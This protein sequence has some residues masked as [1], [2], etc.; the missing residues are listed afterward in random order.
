MNR[1]KLCLF[2][3]LLALFML[4][5]LDGVQA[6]ETKSSAID[7]F[8]NLFLSIFRT[9]GK[10]YSTEAYLYTPSNEN[11]LCLYNSNSQLSA[12][13]CEYYLQKRSGAHS[14]VLNLPEGMFYPNCNPYECSSYADFISYV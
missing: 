6:A 13:I 10:A 9:V 7:Q 5:N 8:I 12:E 11:A 3:F 4:A 1:V 14:L 2:L